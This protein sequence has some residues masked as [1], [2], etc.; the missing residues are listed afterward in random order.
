MRENQPSRF[1]DCTTISV[2]RFVQDFDKRFD[3]DCGE[4]FYWDE[5]F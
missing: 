4:K 1:T 2:A 3:I 5:I